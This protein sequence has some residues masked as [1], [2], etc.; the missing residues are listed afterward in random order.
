MSVPLRARGVRKR[1][2]RM[3]RAAAVAALAAMTIRFLTLFGSAGCTREAEAPAAMR[4]E[5]RRGPGEAT[6]P[7]SFRD[8]A[9]ELGLDRTFPCGGDGKA[10]IIET[11]G[12]GVAAFD[13]DGDGRV[14]LC[15]PEAG[16]LEDG[17]LAGGRAVVFFHQ[18]EDGR[19]VERTRESGLSADAWAIGC[20]VGDTDGDGDLDLFVTTWGRNLLFENR[21]DGTFVEVGAKRGLIDEALSTSAVFLDYDADGDLDLY[22]ANYVEFDPAALPNGGQ[23]CVES[24]V[25]IACGP[26]FHEP[27]RDHFYENQGDGTFVEVG[28]RAGI[29]READAYG[30]AVAA[31]DLDGDGRI[32]LYV[33][34]D[35]TANFLWRNRG[36]GTFEDL[37]VESG[38]GL[39]AEGQGQAG[40]GIAIADVDGDGASDLFVTNYSQEPNALYLAR[41]GWFEERA[42]ATGLGGQVAYRALGWGTLFVDFNGDGADELFV[43]NGH[44][45]PRAAELASGLAWAEPCH[46]W[47]RS[48]ATVPFEGP[49]ELG[50]PRSH[51][52]AAAADLDR[53][54]VPEIIVTAVDSRPVVLRCETENAS[55]SIAVEL[56]G[57][58]SN[59]EGIGAEI[60]VVAGGRTQ[61]RQVSRGGSY[62]AASEAV[63]RFGLGSAARTE[64]VTIR[65]P[66]GRLQAVGPLAA[67]SLYEVTEGEANPREILRFP[68][69]GD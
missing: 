50:S 30:L 31:A 6:L 41:E 21:G 36:D 55:T 5:S 68:S 34:N 51:R 23:P 2:H 22:V 4:A 17:E 3:P 56:R 9:P 69:R 10:T 27:A 53:D 8:I 37:G 18:G 49:L 54:G 29:A 25:P 47:T 42:Q 48:K 45:Y 11:L 43:A 38:A 39:G 67:G 7:F 12:S 19:F 61:V 64:R 15:F 60:T 13:A 33:A 16:T 66:S 28:E 59:R 52:A 24:G 35:T 26:G 40:M 1:P 57:V 62:L 32:D 65:W 46:L 20:A 58:A 63:A 44:V 14:D